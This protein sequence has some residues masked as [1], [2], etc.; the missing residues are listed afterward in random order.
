M[1]ISN[2]ESIIQENYRRLAELD[3][4][5]N[6][7][8]G[9]GS[10]T[11]R[12]E[13]KYDRTLSLYLPTSMRDLKEMQIYFEFDS[14]Y[15]LCERV[16]PND[17]QPTKR[18]QALEHINSIRLDHDF[19]F[20][21]STCMTIYDKEGNPVKFVLNY[22]QRILLKELE[23]MR[24]AD[25]PIRIILLKA[26][27][28]GGSTLVQLYIAWIQLR[29]C[30]RWNSAVCTTVENQAR[31]IRGMFTKMAASHPK[32]IADIV[33][34]P[35]E[36]SAKNKLIS[37]RDGVI[38]IGSYEEPE[39]LRGNTFQCLHASEVASWKDTEGK[40]AAEFLQS[41][42]AAIPRRKNTVIAIESTAK[43]VGNFFHKEWVSATNS[44][45]GYRP[46]FIPWFIIQDYREKINDYEEFIKGMNDKARGLWDLG[47]T[48]EAI[49]WYMA[50]QSEENFTDWQMCEE[51]P[52]TANEAFVSSGERVFSH[53]DIMAMREYCYTAE[54]IGELQGDKMLGKEALRG[55]RFLN[56]A[57]GNFHVWAMPDTSIQ[58]TNRYCVFVDIGGKTKKAD[59]SVIRVLDRYWQSIGEP[60]EF[61]ATWRGHVDH[62]ILAWKAAQ[63]A[64]WYNNALLAIE[65]NST[66]KKD[67]GSGHF[68]TII[69]QLANDY[70]NMFARNTPDSVVEGRPT[71]YGFHTNQKSKRLIIDA[72]IGALRDKQ[73]IERDVRAL[74]EMETYEI[75][76]NKS[77]GAKDGCKDDIVMT[78]AGCIWLG[79]E[80]MDDCVQI[81]YDSDKSRRR[82]S[83]IVNESSI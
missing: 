40:T 82:K 45:S 34:N 75:K 73:Y 28:W 26:R 42:R 49:K 32:E 44:T 23:E 79:T 18:K 53:E 38:A 74:D 71:K 65:E 59:Y 41:L 52:S 61:V 5:Y 60:C 8:T 77:L 78:S 48:L 30:M 27:Q 56:N 12:F 3:K 20:Y 37:G 10:L 66:D 15:D 70:Q 64:T 25:I 80:Y 2:I 31:H 72:L 54:F 58:V 17:H 4:R 11:D 33:L 68:Y 14:I 19:E 7:L 13:L 46:I 24:L 9:E 22:P 1:D 6:P 43:G 35:Y 63:I 67:D 21:A 36:G 69:D 50:F 55:L 57:K 51:Y 83:K 29:L 81:N 47:A 62:D 16:F 39:T 76:E